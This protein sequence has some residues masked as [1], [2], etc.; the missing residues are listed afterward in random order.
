MWRWRK[1]ENQGRGKLNNIEFPPKMKF[2]KPTGIFTLLRATPRILKR[3][4]PDSEENPDFTVLK[5]RK[6]I[7]YLN[8]IKEK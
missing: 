1:F 7:L 2:K 5:E 6:I 8:L 3:K 4:S